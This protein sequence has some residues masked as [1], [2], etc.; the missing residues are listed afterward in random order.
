[1]KRCLSK[2]ER[3]ALFREHPRPD[4]HSCSPPKVNKYI[5][6]FLGKRLTKEHDAELAKIQSAVLAIIRPLT[7]AWQHLIDS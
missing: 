4:L 2:E 7:S 1:M 5:S 6:E 3:E